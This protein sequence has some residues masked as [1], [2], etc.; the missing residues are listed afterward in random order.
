MMLGV[1][2][3]GNTPTVVN[4]GIIASQIKPLDWFQF[5]TSFFTLGWIQPA[6]MLINELL[7]IEYRF[8][9]YE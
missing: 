6:L 1:V 9:D 8:N 4:M 5:Y 3:G 2:T 7:S